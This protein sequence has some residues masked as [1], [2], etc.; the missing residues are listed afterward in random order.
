MGCAQITDITTRKCVYN[1][2]SLKHKSRS[3]KTT[4]NAFTTD[5]DKIQ[6]PIQ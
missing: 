6:H 3:Q 2:K 4:T 1:L 5:A